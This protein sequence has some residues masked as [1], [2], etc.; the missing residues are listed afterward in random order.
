MAQSLHFVT[1]SPHPKKMN[2]EWKAPRIHCADEGARAR[3]GQEALEI[4]L[5]DPTCGPWWSCDSY[6]GLGSCRGRAFGDRAWTPLGVVRSPGSGK[7]LQTMRATLCFPN[8]RPPHLSTP[9]PISPRAA[10]EIAANLGLWRTYV[11]CVVAQPPGP[12]M[13]AALVHLIGRSLLLLQSPWLPQDAQESRKS[14]AKPP[15]TAASIKDHIMLDSI[16]VTAV[17]S[18]SSC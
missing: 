2:L 12:G 15:S 14:Q 17:W 11:M 18:L 5:Q 4:L 16:N 1:F 13:L 7:P 8:P 3:G 6:P 10:S 9:I